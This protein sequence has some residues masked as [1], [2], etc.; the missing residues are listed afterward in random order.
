MARAGYTYTDTSGQRWGKVNGNRWFK[1]GTAKVRQYCARCGYDHNVKDCA[2][3][4]REQ[5]ATKKGGAR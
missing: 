5:A 4:L 2:I 1:K 3:A